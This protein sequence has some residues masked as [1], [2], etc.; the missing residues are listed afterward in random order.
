MYVLKFDNRTKIY[1]L[2][3]TFVGNKMVFG[4]QLDFT[5][6]STNRYQPFH[7]WS[8]ISDKCIFKKSQCIENG[9]FLYR[10]G[11]NE[12]DRSCR[13]DYTLGY[14]F[15]SKPKNKCYCMPSQEECSCYKKNCPNNE[16]LTPG[17]KKS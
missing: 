13:C 1:L 10:N 5:Q 6:C 12:S 3:N 8:N 14:A 11:T 4:G 9:Q 17:K 2:S 16:D 15:I 7:M